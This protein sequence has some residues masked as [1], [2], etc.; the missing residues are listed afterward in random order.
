MNILKKIGLLSMVA[1]SLFIEAKQTLFI[2][3]GL[4]QQVR[5][6]LSPENHQTSLCFLFDLHHVLFKHTEN[7]YTSSAL[8][9]ENKIIF[10][11]QAVRASVS[12]TFWKNFKKLRKQKNKVTEAYVSAL[13]KYPTLH[14]G[15][16]TFMNDLYVPDTTMEQYTQELKGQGHRLY[17]LSNI[18]PDLLTDL[19][20]RHP[21]FFK[22]FDRQQNTINYQAYQKNIWVSK[23][24]VEAY[25]HALQEISMQD[26]ACFC[27]FV[28]DKPEN[29]TGAC[30]A[31]LNAI[32]FVSPEQF[33]QDVRRLLNFIKTK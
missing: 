13:K 15:L 9:V 20:Q 19:Q 27:V 8:K 25:Q 10:T 26:Q 30:K 6:T 32:L 33:K 28:D 7:P 21:T 18:G 12:P 24:H 23:P 22:H 31:G 2:S 29:I 11:L 3:D 1:S 4:K 17:L 14:K 5:I 16:L